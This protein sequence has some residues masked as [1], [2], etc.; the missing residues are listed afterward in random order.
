MSRCHSYLVENRSQMKKKLNSSLALIYIPYRSVE[1]LIL[2]VLGPISIIYDME[3]VVIV[4]KFLNSAARK[5]NQ[6]LLKLV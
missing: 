1:F 2:Y 4:G 3:I 5:W 6:L